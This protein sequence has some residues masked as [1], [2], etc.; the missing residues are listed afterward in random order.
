MTLYFLNEY[1]LFKKLSFYAIK[2]TYI[3]A[4]YI[5]LNLMKILF[6]TNQIN[7]RGTT[8]AIADYA[9][10]NQEILG[11]ESVIGYN[12]DIMNIEDGK[13]EFDALNYLK[14]YF[15]LRPYKFIEIDRSLSDIDF[16]YFLRAGNNEPT[17]KSVRSGVHAVFQYNE[18]HGDVYAYI[19]KWLSCKMSDSLLP[20]VPHI[21][22]LPEPK[23]N[24]RS[25]LNIKPE[26]VVIGRLGGLTTFD[27]PFVKEAII[28]IVKANN[29]FVFL[30]LNTKPFISHPNIKYI[31]AVVDPQQKSDFINT[32]DGFVHARQQ[33]ESFGLAICECLL[34][35]KPVL[36]FNGGIDRH[37]IDLLQKTDL[38]YDREN[39][40]EKLLSITD[41]KRDWKELVEEFNPKDTMK[42]FQDVFLKGL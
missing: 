1:K 27:I 29:K 20:Y 41:F 5:T 42:K 12:S 15:E 36:A 22:T 25:F 8:V 18:P 6:H 34:L 7:F 31:N 9:K 23:K 33:G 16:A 24:Y 21:V 10:Y 2:S 19:S 39:V 17:P 30:F 28:E 4:N 11:N 14:K 37:H 13:T 35:N 32:C 3:F 40:K 26:Q 38:L